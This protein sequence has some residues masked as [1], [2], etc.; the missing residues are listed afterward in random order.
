LSDA[1]SDLSDTRAALA[2]RY[3]ELSS[4]TETWTTKLNDVA[5]RHNVELTDERQKALEV[6][7]SL[8]H[9]SDS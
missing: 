8:S 2:S 3:Q 5:A 9:A 4:L 6:R 1:E 7:R